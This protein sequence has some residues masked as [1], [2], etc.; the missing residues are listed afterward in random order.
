MEA[1][2]D[3]EEEAEAHYLE[4]EADFHDVVALLFGVGVVGG[5]GGAANDLDQEGDDIT[6]YE[7][8]R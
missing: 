4:I 1:E 5:A 8:R 6:G 2:R 7:Y 3:D